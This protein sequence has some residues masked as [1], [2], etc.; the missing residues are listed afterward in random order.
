MANTFDRV[1]ST[2]NNLI[3]DNSQ[4]SG[5]TICL[6][7]RNKAWLPDRSLMALTKRQESA[8]FMSEEPSSRAIFRI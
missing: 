2:T 1:D 8:T 5:S 6:I 7:R 3:V 4:L